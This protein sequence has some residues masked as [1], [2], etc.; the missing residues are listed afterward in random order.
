MIIYKQKKSSVHEM[1][2]LA[3][4]WHKPAT[5]F[6]SLL[7]GLL[8]T[9]QPGSHITE[10]MLKRKLNFRNYATVVQFL[11][12]FKFK[13]TNTKYRTILLIIKVK[14]S[15]KRET[16]VTYSVDTD[17]VLCCRSRGRV[18]QVWHKSYFES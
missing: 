8:A 10:V 18:G 5:T 7:H 11:S 4:E 9:L 12:Q 17:L 6:I 2:E 1:C 16:R 13:F 14:K 3:P 15:F